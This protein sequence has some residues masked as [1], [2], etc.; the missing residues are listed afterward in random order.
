MYEPGFQH[1]HSVVQ[2]LPLSVSRTF[3]LRP[4]KKLL[5]VLVVTSNSALSYSA[6]TYYLLWG[7]VCLSWAFHIN[8]IRRCIVFRVWPLSMFSV[9]ILIVCVRTSL[10]LW[11]NSIP[12]YGYSIFCIFIYQLMNNY[13]H[14]L[15]IMKNITMN[16][17][18]QV[19]VWTCF[20][21]FMYMLPGVELLGQKVNCQTLP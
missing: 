18:V 7:W 14:F 19:F 6:T 20:S 4:P 3:P 9:F 5:S 21:C 15:A 10:F 17:L 12:L 11:Q 16:I 13:F 2:L 1:L 8:R